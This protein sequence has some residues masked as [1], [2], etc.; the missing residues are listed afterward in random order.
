MA[1]DRFDED[2]YDWLK[3]VF[4]HKGVSAVCTEFMGKEEAEEDI[5]RMKNILRIT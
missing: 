2:V 1:S 3:Y 4:E 5:Q